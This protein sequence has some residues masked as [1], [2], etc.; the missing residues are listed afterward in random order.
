[1]KCGQQVSPALPGLVK[2]TSC[3][4]TL[5]HPADFVFRY[6]KAGGKLECEHC[7][8]E[9]DIWNAVMRVL[10]LE[11]PL[12]GGQAYT[13]LGAR[14]TLFPIELTA[15]QEPKVN[16]IE[17]GV[18]EKSHIACINYTPRNGVFPL[19]VHG[20]QPRRGEQPKQVTLFGRPTVEHVNKSAKVNIA[21]AWIPETINFAPWQSLIQAIDAFAQKHYA[22]MV[23]PANVFVETLARNALS[24]LMVKNLPRKRVDDFLS[25]G[26]SYSHQINVLLPI[27]ATLW[28]SNR[29]RTESRG[30]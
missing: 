20:N 8:S 11:F 14:V 30:R 3:N 21:V 1:M 17:A 5:P 13:F 2:C 25:N 9:V 15:N 27:F 23:I 18:P 19:E 12:L 28:H 22:Q 6:F 4:R 7:G 29:C 16:F 24:E 26:V 10:E